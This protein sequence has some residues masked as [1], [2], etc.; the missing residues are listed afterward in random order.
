[1]LSTDQRSMP[2]VGIICSILRMEEGIGKLCLIGLCLIVKVQVD[3]LPWPKEMNFFLWDLKKVAYTGQH[4]MD[5]VG[6][7]IHNLDLDT[8]VNSIVCDATHLYAGTENGVFQSTDNGDTWTTINHGLTNQNVSVLIFD[9]SYLFAGTWGGGVFRTELHDT[10]WTEINTGLTNMDITS[11]AIDGDNFFAGTWQGAV[12]GGIFLSKNN[13][14]HWSLVSDALTYPRPMPGTIQGL[15]VDDNYLYAGGRDTGVWRRLLSEVVSDSRSTADHPPLTFTLFQN[16]PNPFNPKTAISYQL[17]VSSHV[18][19]SI[20]NLL[21]QK[22]ATLVSERQSA[23][24]YKVEWDAGKLSSGVYLCR[25]HAGSHI[26]TKKMILI[27]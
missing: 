15:A 11:F 5:R 7:L 2:V 4:I 3:Y 14:D 27:K 26:Q 12:N 8:V 16:Y 6:G 10:S 17:P 9:D 18:D 22:V 20:Y 19:L 23:G 13:G 21:G 1:L 24:A 25:L